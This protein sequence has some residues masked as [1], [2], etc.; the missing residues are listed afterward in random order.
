MS[1]GLIVEVRRAQTP[2]RPSCR[3]H[4]ALD[5]SYGPTWH[6]LIAAVQ[7]AASSSLHPPSPPRSSPQRF[8][9]PFTFH[10]ALITGSQ[11]IWEKYFL[12]EPRIPS[13]CFLIFVYHTGTDGCTCE[14]GNGQILFCFFS[15]DGCCSEQNRW[16]NTWRDETMCLFSAI[17]TLIKEAQK[18]LKDIL[19]K[20]IKLFALNV[21]LFFFPNNDIKTDTVSLVKC[22]WFFLLTS[23][24]SLIAQ[25]STLKSRLSIFQHP[26]ETLS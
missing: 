23:H 20:T 25:I 22:S 8:V 26:R 16:M 17:K 10:A 5:T 24:G 3:G 6:T 19:Y 13:P 21:N 18:H 11:G 2:C 12:P 4:I 9:I 14:T 15:S 1:K 7:G